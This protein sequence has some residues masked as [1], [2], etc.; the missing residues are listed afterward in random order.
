MSKRAKNQPVTYVFI[1][2]QNLKLGVQSL[3]WSLDWRRFR[4]YLKHK[5]HVEKAFLF[6]GFLPENQQLY[7]SLQQAGYII[8]FKTVLIA[9]DGK[10]KGNVDAELVLHTMIEH[11]NYDQAVIVTSDGD[12]ACLVEYL[13]EQKKLAK[14]ISPQYEK[15]SILLKRAAHERIA[16]LTDLRAKLEYKNGASQRDETASAIPRRG[17]SKK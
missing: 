1:D 15:C 16:F 10:I 4:V 12:F 5:Y 17:D 13:Y 11:P 7:S 8:I 6:I 14:V 9:S 2:T 3:G